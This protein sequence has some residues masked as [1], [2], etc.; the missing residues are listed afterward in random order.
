MCAGARGDYYPRVRAPIPSESMTWLRRAVERLRA[1][2]PHLVVVLVLG[3]VAFAQRP[4]E[5]TFDTKLDLTEDPL[6]FL[7][8]ALNLWNPDGGFGELQN[9]A[10]GYLFPIGPFFALADLVGLPPWVAQR[11]WT[12]LLLVLAYAGVVAVCRALPVGNRWSWIVAGLAYALSPRVITTI[13]PISAETLVVALLPWSL[14]PLLRWRSLGVRRAAALSAVGMLLMGAANA[15]LVLAVVPLVGLVVLAQPAGVRVRLVAWVTACI[16]LACAWWLGALLVFGRYS[17]PFLDYIESATNTTGGIGLPEA[18]RGATHWVAWV[19]IGQQPWWPAGHSVVTNPLLI[20][21]TTA[22]GVVGLLGLLDRRVPLRSAFLISATIGLLVLTLGSSGELSSPLAEWWHTVLDGPLSPFRNVHKFD[23]LVRL[24]AAIGIAHVGG[25]LIKSGLAVNRASVVGSLAAVGLAACVVAPLSVAINPGLRPGP[26]WDE[27]PSWWREAADYVA[28]RDP[29]ARTLVLPSTGFGTQVWGRTVDE[30]IQPLA[31]APWVS[32]SQVFLGS[33]GAARLVEGLDDWIESGRGSPVLGDVLARAGVRFVIVRG[34]LEPRRSG[35]PP[36]SVVRQALERS[37]GIKRSAEF[38]PTLAGGAESGLRVSGHGLEAGVSAIEVYEVEAEVAP[39]RLAAA[40]DLVEVAGGPESI[41]RLIEDGLLDPAAPTVLAMD[42]AGDGGRF[43]MTDDPVRRERNFG[44]VRDNRGPVMSEDEPPRLARAAH[45]ILPPGSDDDLSTA[46]YAGIA[47]VSASTSRGYVDSVMPTNVALAPWAAVDG[48]PFTVWRSDALD[49]PVGEWLQLDM[50]EAATFSQVRVRFA[51]SSL[52]GSR[53]TAVDVYT[54]GG[55]ARNEVLADGS[56]ETLDLPPGPTDFVRIEIAATD[57][58]PTGQV[59]IVEI[60]LPD[61]ETGRLVAAAAKPEGRTTP[62]A[63]ISLHRHEPVRNAC[64]VVNFSIRCDPNLV[65]EG[66][67]AALLARS[68][69]TPASTQYRISGTAYPRLGG[70]VNELF[71]PL[72]GIT[73]TASSTLGG[74]PAVAAQ[75]AVDGNPATSWVAGS[76]DGAPTLELAWAEDRDIAAMRLTSAQH[77]VAARPTKVTVSIDGEEWQRDVVDGWVLIPP[78]RTD[79]VRVTITEWT[80]VLS[81]DPRGEGTTRVSPGISELEIPGLEDLLVPPDLD[82]PTGRHC[83]LGP[84]VVIDGQT[85]QTAVTGT[86]RDVRE[87]RPLRWYA[88]GQNA[89]GVRLGRG[90]HVI[91]VHADEMFAADSILLRDRATRPATS[92]DVGSVAVETWDRSRRTVRVTTVEPAVLIV[93]ENANDGWVA[94]LDGEELATSRVDGWQQGWRLPAGA[95]GVVE[96]EFAPQRTFL[97]VLGGGAVAAVA[98]AV[99]AV[100]PGSPTPVPIARAS[101]RPPGRLRR[102]VTWLLAGVMGAAAAGLAGVLAFGTAVLVRPTGRAAGLLIPI[103]GFT[104]VAGVGLAQLLHANVAAVVGAFAMV[105]VAAAVGV[106]AI[107]SVT[108]DLG[109]RVFQPWWRGRPWVVAAAGLILAQL[110][111]RAAALSGAFF[112]HDDYVY[113]SNAAAGLSADYLFQ[114][115][116]GHLMPG[117]FLLVWVLQQIAPMQW[118]LAGGLVIVLQL[119][120]SLLVLRLVRDMVGDG[121]MGFVLFAVYA[122]SPLVFAASVWWAS[123]LQALPLQICLAWALLAQ[124]RYLRTGSRYYLVSALAALLVGLFFW[125]KAMLIVAVLVGFTLL[126]APY[127]TEKRLRDLIRRSAAALTAYVGIAIAYAGAWLLRARF[128][129]ETPATAAEVAQLA[130]Y[131][132][133]D[134]FLPGLLGA[135]LG[136][137]PH[138]TLMAPDPHWGVRVACALVFGGGAVLVV[139]VG[140]WKALLPVA[141]VVAY[142][143][144]DV[145]LVAAAR[146]DFIGPVIGRDVRYTVDAVIVAVVALAGVGVA[147]RGRGWPGATRRM[148]GWIAGT[149]VLAVAAGSVASAAGAMSRLPMNEARGYVESGLAAAQRTGGLDLVDSG[150]PQTVMSS[151]FV[152]SARASVVFSP[153]AKPP[154]FY[155]PSADLR[156]LDSS[157]RP[158]PV[159]VI[160]FARSLPMWSI[161]PCARPVRSGE[162]T[163]P[164]DQELDDGNWI[165]RVTYLGGYPTT[166]R[167]AVGEYQIDVD[168]LAGPHHLYVELPGRPVPGAVTL[169][170]LPPGDA[171]CV[172][173]V[174]VG[175]AGEP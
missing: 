84:R 7:G 114:S 138:S 57:G 16:G 12:A 30:P 97:A 70:S 83:G 20:I 116:G 19:P 68:F 52:L 8:R 130:R 17:T 134:T 41:P 51:S 150:V 1:R 174:L 93:R 108:G 112:W 26:G 82:T 135:T 102:L 119:I 10:Y 165:V 80:T 38:G 58:E 24:P 92:S 103:V 61:L 2:W 168:F 60:D 166:G 81:T 143:I 14:L 53:V 109:D 105:P 146:L 115:Y 167:L 104:A 171:V 136:D 169:G 34:D 153:A 141:L 67:E 29:T 99:L 47:G 46:R 5:T 154:R 156:I 161:H 4:G 145:G 23:P 90:Q 148:R 100:F 91:E 32:R 77:P 13:G 73:A 137:A 43:V 36:V 89:E 123:A 71:Q 128:D 49:G 72:A 11:I 31:G 139:R 164:L 27:L 33:E 85:V 140:G 157:G 86:I 55:V 107:R 152:D 48:D 113:L 45:D 18:V 162:R 98:L 122:L 163:V 40:D 15:T 132:V 63:G 3:F 87:S 172:T 50:Y 21:A 151:L 65:R 147:L 160:P 117:Q 76:F 88:C 79:S 75:W 101:R 126:V 129:G 110:G 159:E 127:V 111:I 131:A 95:S 59:G 62:P 121:P 133:A 37:G 9:Q 118:W 158:R 175:I 173:D 120:A 170:G 149:V 106:A 28:E 56:T 35:A 144:A 125:Q 74:D 64:I 25:L 69:T 22:A 96:L 142:L 94:R 39:V 44:R 42:V 6:G 78:S 155:A 124:L 54:E 66:D